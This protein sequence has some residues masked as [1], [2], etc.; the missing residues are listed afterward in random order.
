[1]KNTHLRLSAF[2]LAAAMLL[3]LAACSKPEQPGETDP[4]TDIETI[5]DS[6]VT[7]TFTGDDADRPGYAEGIIEIEPA[8][9]DPAGGSY[10]LCYADG[11]AILSDYEP[12]AV[13]PITG[14]AVSFNMIRKMAL[15][16]TAE[17]IAVFTTE[18]G[19]VPADASLS[20]ARLA[21]IPAEKRFASG[22]TELRFA[23]VSDLHLDGDTPRSKWKTAVTTFKE[24]DLPLIVGCGDYSSRGEAEC[25]T[26]F[27]DVLEET[28]YEGTFW[29]CIGNHDTADKETW[30]EYF[31][32]Y[33]PDGDTL[34]FYEIAPNG[35]V[36]IFMAQD[37][38]TEFESGKDSSDIE[39]FSAEEIDWLEGVLKQYANTG[40]NIF[41]YCHSN[42]LNWGAGFPYPSMDQHGLYI[43]SKYKNTVRLK[44][45]LDEYKEVIYCSG[46]THA[47]YSLGNVFNDI[48]GTSARMFHISSIA[49]PRDMPETRDTYTNSTDETDSEASICT[50][51]ENDIVYRGY[52]FAT[53]TYLP[54]ACFIV[55]SYSADH[56]DKDGLV[57]LV[58]DKDESVTAYPVGTKTEDL[59][60]VVRAEF[61]DGTRR[62]V[63]DYSLVLYGKSIQP[64]GTLLTV[65]PDQ[66]ATGTYTTSALIT[67]GGQTLYCPI[68]PK[69]GN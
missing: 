2:L 63:D 46:H 42:F 28:G 52:N 11:D 54:E 23:S 22:E 56:S 8:E 40:V 26:A 62:V 53:G 7:Y 13:L 33:G 3:S 31:R 44:A 36:F 20:D 16:E 1:M 37:V 66:E 69:A 6:G 5:E 30:H 48:D 49:S 60:Y 64:W 51:Y 47:R 12:I 27:S 21:V 41:V 9:T 34:Y 35:D 15:P 61:E 4:G 17:Q 18:D 43:T 68:T 58:M 59:H 10:V 67:W 32:P 19:S 14:E 29:G 50:V 57:S 55:E 25:F 65:M 45:L 24:F 39:N 38:I